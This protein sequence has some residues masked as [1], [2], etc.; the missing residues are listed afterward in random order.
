MKSVFGLMR[1]GAIHLNRLHV[2]LFV[3]I[4]NKVIRLF[5]LAAEQVTHTILSKILALCVQH[6][7]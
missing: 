6:I 4:L 1:R 2:G 5:D 7:K 3:E